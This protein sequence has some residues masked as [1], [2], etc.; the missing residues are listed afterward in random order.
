MV[1]MTNRLVRLKSSFLSKKNE[2][3]YSTHS[4]VIAESN[5]SVSFLRA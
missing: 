3:P 2:M 5:R 1:Q 4:S